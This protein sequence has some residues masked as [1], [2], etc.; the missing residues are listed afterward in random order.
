M[1]WCQQW[2]TDSCL[3]RF[4][5]V[6]LNLRRFHFVQSSLWVDRALGNKVWYKSNDSSF[7]LFYCFNG[8]IIEFNYSSSLPLGTAGRLNHSLNFSCML[9]GRAGY[10]HFDISL[11]L[12]WLII[13]LKTVI[14]NPRGY[15]NSKMYSDYS[16]LL[17]NFSLF[18]FALLWQNSGNWSHV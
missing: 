17:S 18:L 4:C 2:A 14:S 15:N 9:T 3:L 8:S 5:L 10:W 12:Q 16:H 7:L 1:K 13:S 11:T 6:K